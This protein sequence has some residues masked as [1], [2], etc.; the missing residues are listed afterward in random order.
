M[1]VQHLADCMAVIPALRRQWT[2][3]EGRLL[4]VGSGG[5]LPGVVI[6]IVAPEWQVTCVDAVAKKAAFVRQVAVELQLP[7]LHAQ[8]A[9]V[10]RFAGRFDVVASRAFAALPEFC[11]LTKDRLSED[12]VWL[13]MKGLV[14]HDELNALPKDIDA[15]HVEQLDVPGLGAQRCIVWMRPVPR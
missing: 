11:R 7:N 6:A 8:H 2:G 15:F 13:A 3:R 4:D 1:V 5:G 14:P 12:G 10:E 9:R